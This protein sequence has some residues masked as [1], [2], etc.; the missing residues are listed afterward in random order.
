MD[1]EN[2]L[3]ET[4]GAVATITLNRPEKLN[5]ISNGMRDDLESALRQLNP[6]DAVRVIRIRG[7]GR[8]FCPGYDLSP[9][10]GGYARGSTAAAGPAEGSDPTDR[11]AAE[12]GE[13][14]IALDR[15]GLRDSAERW[16]RMWNYRKPIVAQ[17]HRYCLA[18]GLDLIGAC[19]IVFAAEGTLLGH[20]A[21][22][23]LGIPPT[24]GMLPAKIG[25]AKTKEL[26]FTGDSIDAAEAERLGLVN[27]VVPADELDQRTMEF[28][29]RVA[30]VPLDALTVH[31][32]ATNRWMELAGVRSAVLETADWDAVYHLTPSFA[33]FGEIAAERGLRAALA[34]RDD[35]FERP[36]GP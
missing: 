3:V 22:R 26:M 15:E 32:H 28:C 33:R 11:G 6:G 21:S 9:R 25:A 31:K 35:P 30:M 16:L 1:F 13:S 2:I 8:A 29:Q 36:A 12:L 14:S 17:I 10:P 18:G 7:A 20:P 4:E 27:H 34:W 19:D 24:L 5:A 23:A